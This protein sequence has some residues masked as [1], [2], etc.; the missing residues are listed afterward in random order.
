MDVIFVPFLSRS[1]FAALV[2]VSEDVLE[3]WVRDGRVRTFRIGKR[4]LVDMRQWIS[5]KHAADQQ[6]PSEQSHS[7]AGRSRRV[8]PTPEAEQ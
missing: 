4:S 6:E 3:R 2:G 7:R 1:R 5:D 8:A